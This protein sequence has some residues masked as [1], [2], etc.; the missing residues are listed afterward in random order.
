MGTCISVY[1]SE[2][3]QSE[4]HTKLIGCQGVTK[5]LFTLHWC[6]KRYLSIHTCVPMFYVCML[7]VYTCH[8]HIYIGIHTC[9][10]YSYYEYWNGLIKNLHVTYTPSWEKYDQQEQCK[11]RVAA[12]SSGNP[13]LN[14]I[15]YFLQKVL[16]ASSGHRQS[17]AQDT[18]LCISL[19][20]L[21]LHLSD[22]MLG[23][24]CSIYHPRLYSSYIMY[25]HDKLGPL[26][27]PSK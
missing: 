2:T 8:T 21:P 23:E 9:I 27:R 16:P 4:Y 1:Q 15:K 11:F 20:M 3:E 25:F 12:K 17:H 18:L 22:L 7:H 26:C 19:V 10:L 5:E 6:R 24:A 14:Q 13:L